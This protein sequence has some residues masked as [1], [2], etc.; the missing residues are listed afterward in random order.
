MVDQTIMSQ[1]P[2][3]DNIIPAFEINFNVESEVLEKDIIEL[4]LYSNSSRENLICTLKMRTDVMEEAITLAG[5]ALI[6]PETGS[7]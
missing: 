1:S 7:I 3:Y 6:V 2:Q 4:P 5:V